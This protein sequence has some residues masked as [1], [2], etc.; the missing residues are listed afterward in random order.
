MKSAQIKKQQRNSTR[1]SSISALVKSLYESPLPSSRSGAL[2]NAF[3]YPTKIS[4]EAIAIFIATHTKPGD[5]ILD[6][7]AGSGTT[8]LATLLCAKPTDG[9]KRMASNLG[10]KPIWGPRRA[11]LYELGALGSFVSRTMCSAPNPAEFDA[12]ANS[13]IASAEQ[14]FGWMYE[15]KDPSGRM[16]LLRHAIWSDVLIC[17]RC[18]EESL[19]ADVAVKRRPFRF[20]DVF[21]CPSCRKSERLDQVEH[22]VETT[23][24]PL[25]RTKV[26]TKKRRLAL[27]YGKT[28]GVN[29]QRKATSADEAQLKKL[30]TA[31]LPKCTPVVEMTW[32]DLQRNGYHRGISHV[33]HFYTRRNLLV[34]AKLWEGID[35]FPRHLQDALRLL[36]LSYN[37]SH[38]TLMT[39][40]V[41]KK[42]QSDFVLTGAQSGIL[43][44]S[45]LPVEKNIF[46]GLR[47][48][49]KVLREAFATVY[50]SESEVRVENASS[51]SL[52]LPSKSIDYVFTDPP[53]G[54]YIPYA[55][56]SQINEAW[57]GTRTRIEEEIIVSPAQGK[58]V[59]AFARLMGNVF[60]EISRVLK[61]DAK[62]TVVFHSSKAAVWRA[63]ADAYAQ[64][65]LAVKASSVLDKLQV[66]FKQVVS[67]VSVKG[68]PLLLLVKQ[69]PSNRRTSTRKPKTE[70]II[71]RLLTSASLQALGSKER[72]AERLYSR[73]VSKC[74]ENG[75]SV[76]MNAESFYNKV[77]EVEGVQ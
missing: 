28:D 23:R 29:W 70:S 77:R 5:T 65:G 8:G 66:S 40:V 37:A 6:A 35:R 74:L 73:F 64:A 25:T 63:L 13:L 30:A 52:D 31:K 55:E 27:L 10:L 20:V 18:Q 34:F 72:T 44:I 75:V 4:P 42:H 1:S 68:D 24:D 56:L 67:D 39:R 50:G 36:V 38:A 16:G 33:H 2:Y 32:G 15:A 45:S 9:L 21:V 57:L 47:R 51:A 48:K 41:A 69:Q 54:D 11:V 58:D 22:A 19:Y 14:Q 7:F 71:T 12:A 43:Y 60:S 61:D 46:L 62:A 53:F 17:P 49:V 76:S 59:S 3:S 26:T